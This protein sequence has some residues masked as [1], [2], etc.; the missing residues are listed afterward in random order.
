M[1][2]MIA[3]IRTATVPCL[4]LLLFGLSI[5]L[6]AQ[7]QSS[8]R[9]SGTVTDQTGAVVVGAT[10]RALNLASGREVSTAT[11]GSGEYALDD[12]APGSYRVSVIRDGF[13]VAAASVV[14]TDSTPVVQNFTLA[15]GALQDTVTVTAGKGSARIAV[16]TPQTVSVA[17][18]ADLEQRRPASTFQA[19]E[20]TPNLIVRETNPARER[21]RLRGLDSSRVLIVIDGERLNNARTDLQT[22]LS[23]GIIDVSQL[24]SAEVVAGAGSSLYGSDALAGTINLVT[25]APDRPDKGVVLGLRLNGDYHSNGRNRRGNVAVNLSNPQAALRMSLSLF[26]NANTALATR[27]SRSKT[28]STLAGSTS[29]FP[30]TMPA[31]IRSSPCRPTA[32]Y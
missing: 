9:V 30:A 18:E 8:V 11:N 29:S 15:P 20:R 31:N 7:P 4:I 32:K 23:P 2:P 28:C 26:R 21:P 3:P 13:A 22:G 1:L 10:V 16:E 14:V 12:L 5:V 25:R 27:P 17:T 24:S 19:I 6:R